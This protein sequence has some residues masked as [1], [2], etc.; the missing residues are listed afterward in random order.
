[1]E[2]AYILNDPTAEQNMPYPC[3]QAV[4]NFDDADWYLHRRDFDDADWYLHR[5]VLGLDNPTCLMM[6][7]DGKS[8]L[9]SG[10]GI[11]EEFPL[12]SCKD[13]LRN[14]YLS[15]ANEEQ[16]KIFLANLGCPTD[17]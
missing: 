7:F 13:A 16:L 8:R 9:L 3:R 1:M 17:G 15:K 11:K 10:S 4:Y 12:F 6:M 14:R 5:R 2:K